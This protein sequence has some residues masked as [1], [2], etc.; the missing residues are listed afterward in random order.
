MI[1]TLKHFAADGIPEGGHNAA[2]SH[3][4]RRELYEFHLKPFYHAVKAG[5]FP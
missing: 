4:G 5:A 1:S 3:T 2:P